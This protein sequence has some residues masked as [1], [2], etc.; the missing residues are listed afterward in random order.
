MGGR[1]TNLVNGVCRHEFHAQN[2][3]LGMVGEDNRVKGRNERD[4]NKEEWK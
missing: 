2:C 3:K 1:Q 4:A